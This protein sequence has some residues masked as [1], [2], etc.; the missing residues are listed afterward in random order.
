VAIVTFVQKARPEIIREAIEARPMGKRPL[1][2]VL[3]SFLVSAL[4]TGGILSGFAS[5]KPDGLEWAIAR[6]TG[7]EMLREPEQGLHAAMTALQ[8]RTAFLPDYSFKKTENRAQGNAADSLG[9][10]VSGVV[11]GVMTLAIVFLSG[12]LL[13]RRDIR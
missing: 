10:G 8:K 6:V 3:I 7:A 12:F 4:L 2:T 9:T 1:R 13:K 5:K 11:G